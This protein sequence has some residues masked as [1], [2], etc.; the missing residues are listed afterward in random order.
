MD[1]T[2]RPEFSVSRLASS[3]KDLE[4]AGLEVAS[5][6]SSVRL[7]EV[8]P[9]T[10]SAQMDEGRR[11][12][13]L[14][15]KLRA[16]YVRVFGDRWVAGEPRA[17]T[18]ERIA[19]GLTELGRYA[20]GSGVSVVMESHGDFCDSITLLA[21]LNRAKRSNVGLLWD[22]H[23]TVVMGHEQPAD[24]LRRLRRHLRHT[25]LKDSKPDGRGVRYVLTGEGTVP[26][27]ETVKALVQQRYRGYYSFEWEKAWHPEIE[28][29]EIAFPHFARVIR[30]YLEE[31]GYRVA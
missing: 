21:I 22:A 10:R 8:Q 20:K 6:G 3:V 11:F 13:D 16:P 25:H 5:L 18:M 4:A 31:A 2:R 24:T 27:R 15:H 19:S 9:A 23:H 1:L 28:E 12:I 17:A 29:P 26:V 7:H 30:G 14:A